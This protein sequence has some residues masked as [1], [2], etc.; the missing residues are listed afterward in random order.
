[1]LLILHNL[2]MFLF[3]S[4]R[5]FRSLVGLVLFDYLFFLHNVLVDAIKMYYFEKCSLMNCGKQSSAREKTR[6][7][8]MYVLHSMR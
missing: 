5:V 8:H 4:I 2:R 6:Y 1:M 3:W 7:L